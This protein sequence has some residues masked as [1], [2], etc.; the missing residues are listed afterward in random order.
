MGKFKKI[1]GKKYDDYLEVESDI[2]HERVSYPRLHLEL[3]DF[4]EA[5]EYK[6]G[7]NYEVTLKL[8]FCNLNLYRKLDSDEECG[9][10]D[11]DIIGIETHGESKKQDKIY[12]RKV[13]KK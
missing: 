9:H 4:P 10:V 5:R 1:E 7:K 13:N 8:K 3:K 6:I 11:F 2:S 12:P